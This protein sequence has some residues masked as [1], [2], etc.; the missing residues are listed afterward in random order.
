MFKNNNRLN[1]LGDYFDNLP[2]PNPYNL[3]LHLSEFIL[4]SV[5][6]SNSKIDSKV[7]I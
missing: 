5:G 4:Y 3:N 2:E 1:T 7:H 6:K